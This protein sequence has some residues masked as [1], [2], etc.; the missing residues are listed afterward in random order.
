[1]GVPSLSQK[2]CVA[3]FPRRDFPNR[4]APQHAGHQ[5]PQLTS[6]G[7][8]ESPF[9]TKLKPTYVIPESEVNNSNPNGQE[10]E[11]FPQMTDRTSRR[12]FLCKTAAAGIAAA[13]SATNADVS[14][15]SDENKDD[16]FLTEA[17][18]KERM[19]PPD[20]GKNS[21]GWSTR[22]GAL[23]AMPAKS[24]ANPRTMCRSANTL[25]RRFTKTSASI[26]RWLACSF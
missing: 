26:P 1:M 21:A 16:K 15:Q 7:L 3:R 4:R 18:W 5:A 6:A 13:A 22:G 12:E 10:D 19:T 9:G 8:W 25:G 23:A 24:A 14:K 17:V 11:E 20:D 2:S